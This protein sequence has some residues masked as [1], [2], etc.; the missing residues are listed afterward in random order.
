M[1]EGGEPLERLLVGARLAGGVSPPA[2]RQFHVVV[3]DLADLH[4]RG[5]VE[6]AAGQLVE[7]G[8]HRRE[9]GFH[10]LRQPG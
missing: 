7:I 3:K 1:A 9:L 5:N 2:D 10:L 6:L 8:L 4:R